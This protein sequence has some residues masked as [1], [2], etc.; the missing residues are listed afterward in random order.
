ME[1]IFSALDTGARGHMTAQPHPQQAS[2]FTFPSGPINHDNLSTNIPSKLHNNEIC[3]C[4]I[5]FY[6]FKFHEVCRT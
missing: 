3:Y 1:I 2:V 6:E 4:V 5:L